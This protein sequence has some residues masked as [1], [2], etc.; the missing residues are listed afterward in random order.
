MTDFVKVN[1]CPIINEGLVIQCKTTLIVP[2]NS[3]HLM[4]YHEEDKD[5]YLAVSRELATK[6]ITKEEYDRL[7]KELGVEDYEQCTREV[8]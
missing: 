7:C 8:I 2:R 5:L 4:V 1:V 3:L 6:T